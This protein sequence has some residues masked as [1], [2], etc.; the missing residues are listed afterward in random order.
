MTATSSGTWCLR[1]LSG[2]AK[3]RTLALEHGENIVGSASDC[4][5]LLAGGDT[6]AKHLVVL[7][8]DIAVALQ[9]IGDAPVRLNGEEVT[10]RRRSLV[11][12][13]EITIGSFRLQLDRSYAPAAAADTGFPESIL[14][15]DGHL[16]EA[17]PPARRRSGTGRRAAVLLMACAALGLAALAAW[18]GLQDRTA[19]PQGP[20]AAA[21]QRAIAGF[22]EVEVLTLPAGQFMVRGYVETRSR[23]LALQGAVEPFGRRVGVSVHA[24][25][26]VIEQ[27]RRY[28]ASSGI[29]LSYQGQGRIVLSG[30]SDDPALRKRVRQLAEDLQPAVLVTDRVRYRDDAQ[31]RDAT[32]RAPAQAQ[33]AQWAAWQA[34]LPA[35]IVGVTDDGNGTRYIQLAN[36]SRYYEGSV[37]RSG[38]RLDRIDGSHLHLGTGRDDA[39]R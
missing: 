19:T 14:C 5:V 29:A 6:R 15:D 30:V 8:G 20:D 26:E 9:R 18:P 11:A 35:R 33:A 22:D 37:L 23:R 7:V 12:G 2:A 4:D 32:R 16:V 34:E 39:A 17:V 21:I 3:G 24:V 25:D 27:A 10:Q 38:T 13:D 31:A 36:G 1:F 28:V